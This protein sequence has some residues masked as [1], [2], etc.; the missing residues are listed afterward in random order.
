MDWISREDSTEATDVSPQGL[1]ARGTSW[2]AVAEGKEKVG[3]DDAG[4]MVA[5]VGR[6]GFGDGDREQRNPGGGNSE[7]GASGVA[8]T[9]ARALPRSAVVALIVVGMA[10]PSMR[11]AMLG[12]RRG[13]R[14]AMRPVGRRLH[15]GE[16]T[17]HGARMQLHRLGHTYGEPGRKHTGETARDPVTAHGSNIRRGR[18]YERPGGAALAIAPREATSVSSSSGTQSMTQRMVVWSHSRSTEP[19]FETNAFW[20]ASSRSSFSS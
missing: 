17:V 14:E 13:R 12:R 6:R 20:A 4:R 16:A 2:W 5:D 3:R 7:W 10:C 18:A 11:C 1:C 15:D 19:R 9:Q 8:V